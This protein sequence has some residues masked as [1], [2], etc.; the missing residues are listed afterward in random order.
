M[1]SNFLKDFIVGFGFILFVFSNTR[2]NST[3]SFEPV[4]HFHKDSKDEMSQ[5]E[6]RSQVTS[7][8]SCRVVVFK[9]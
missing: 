3:A 4:K 1:H 8:V 6:H 9:L 2:L 7:G 5:S